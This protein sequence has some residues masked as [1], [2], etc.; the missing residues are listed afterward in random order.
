MATEQYLQRWID[1]VVLKSKEYTVDTM[2]LEG[3]LY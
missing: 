3:I 1:T 2:V